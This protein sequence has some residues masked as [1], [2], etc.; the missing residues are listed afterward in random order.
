MYSKTVLDSAKGQIR[1]VTQK[2]VQLILKMPQYYWF[3]LRFSH[4]QTATLIIRDY[5]PHLSDINSTKQLKQTKRNII[6][7]HVL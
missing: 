6:A 3:E 2:W 1:G 7:N 4:P 5:G